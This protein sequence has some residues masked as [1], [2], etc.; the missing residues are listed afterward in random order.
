MYI[1]LL[2]DCTF[3]SNFFS[4]MTSMLISEN[5]YFNIDNIYKKDIDESCIRFRLYIILK[6]YY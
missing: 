5:F 1:L 2:N 4:V 6:I 3:S